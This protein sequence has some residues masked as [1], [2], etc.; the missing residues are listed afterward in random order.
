MKTV[1]TLLF[2]LVIFSS[3]PVA[4]D[5]S[6]WI[7]GEATSAKTIQ[8]NSWYN[9]V[10]KSLLSGGKWIGHFGN[11]KGSASY[12]FTAQA[13]GEYHFWLRANPVK[14]KLRFR[15]NQQS[16]KDLD[17]N[18]SFEAINMASDGKPDLRFV[19]WISGGVLQL[20]AGEN[21]IDIEFL[22][23]HHFHGG[24]DCF[25]L[26]SDADFRPSKTQKPGEEKPSWEAPQITESN[27]HEWMRFVEPSEDELGWRNLRWHRSLSE[28]A[29][30][31]R[32]L[33]RPVLLWAM[34]GH[35]CGET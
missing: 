9:S 13:A 21:R 14:T 33:N 20:E 31:A 27:F 6:I 10:N 16:W 17:F 15:L 2:A 1:A 32:K 25:C 26:T 4:G 12:V 23:N 8:T 29:S 18:T 28:A 22:S 30:E 34:N 19:S 3:S 11:Q 5:S 35:P 7:E 24:L